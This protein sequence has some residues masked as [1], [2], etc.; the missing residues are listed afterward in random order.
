MLRT[1]LNIITLC[2]DLRILICGAVLAASLPGEIFA[3]AMAQSPP[4]STSPDAAAAIFA[5]ALHQATGAPAQVSLG[6]QATVRLSNDLMFIPPAGSA[7]NCS[8]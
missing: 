7:I 5:A 8:W 4:A 6:N 2:L 1:V 3:P